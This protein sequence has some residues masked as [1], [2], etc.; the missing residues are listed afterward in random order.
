MSGQGRPEAVIVAHNAE[1]LHKRTPVVGSGGTFAEIVDQHRVDVM[2][3]ARVLQAAY[4]PV[5]I[6][7]KAVAQVD[8][9]V[10]RL[11]ATNAWWHTSMP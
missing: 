4:T 11:S 5:I 8:G 6:G 7:R 9:A 2:V 1:T 3:M 10:M